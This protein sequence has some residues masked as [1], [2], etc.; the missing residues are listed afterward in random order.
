MFNIGAG[1]FI[2][3]AV[4]A[5]ILVGP[6]RLPHV[7]TDAA[8]LIKKFRSLSQLA[9]QEL[10]SNLGP[11]YENLEVADLHPKKFIQKH[12]TSQLDGAMDEPKAALDEVKKIAK[13]DPDLL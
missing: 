1:E 7:A 3:L 8:K 6:D 5:L 11:G 2:A 13:I 12:L 9:T 10:R 4:L